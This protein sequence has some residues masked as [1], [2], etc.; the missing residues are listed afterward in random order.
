MNN[1]KENNIE[2]SDEDEED[3]ELEENEDDKA[4]DSL[5]NKNNLDK[6]NQNIVDEKNTQESLIQKEENKNENKNIK[7]D[8]N[9]EEDSNENIKQKDMKKDI[10]LSINKEN[11]E[12]INKKNFLNESN[13]NN[14]NSNEIKEKNDIIIPKKTNNNKYIYTTYQNNIFYVDETDDSSPDNY[15]KS[16]SKK[17]LSNSINNKSIYKRTLSI[18]ENEEIESSEN[19]TESYEEESEEKDDISNNINSLNNSSIEK[20]CYLLEL[21]DNGLPNIQ[22]DEIIS[23]KINSLIN[24]SLNNGISISKDI[25]MITNAEN[26]FPSPFFLNSLINEIKIKNEK[27]PNDDYTYNLSLKHQKYLN[28]LNE[29][30]NILKQI[31]KYQIFPNRINTK[32]YF[33]INC[34]VSGNVTFIFL[35]KSSKNNLIQ[36]TKPFHILVNPLININN[37]LIEINQIQMQRVIPKNIGNLEKDFDKFYSK[38]SLLGYNFIHFHSFQKLSK[39]ENIFLIK[40]QNDL[41]DRLFLNESNSNNNDI[42]NINTKQKYQLLLNSIKNLKN[43]YSIGSITDIILNQT[44]SESSWIFENKDCTYNLKNTPWLNVAYELDQIL[45]EYSSLFK[46]KKVLCKSAPYIYNIND[47]E[48]IISEI[49][50]L[51]EKNELEQYF[52]INEE[53]YLNEFKE[54]Y[55]KLKNEEFKK[56]FYNKKNMILND[57]VKNCENKEKKLAEIFTDINYLY[58]LMLQCCI[59]YG[60]ERFGVKICTEFIAIIILQ[61]FKEVNKIN[62]LPTENIFLSDVKNIINIINQKWKKQIKELLK[63]SLSNIKENLKYKYLQLKH[64]KKIDQLIDSYFIIKNKNDPS[65]IF[66]SNGWLMESNDNNNNSL[67]INTVKYGAWHH[68]KRNIIINKN[69]IKINYGENIENTSLFLINHITEYISNLAFI[70]DGLYIDSIRYIPINILKY[71]IYVARKVNPSI[72]LMSNIT[73]N[74][75]NISVQIKKKYTEELGINLFINELIWNNTINETIN[76][77]IKDGSSKNSNIYSENITHFNSELYSSS[78]VGENKILLGKYKSLKPKKPLNILYDSFDNKTYYEKFKK[79]SLS[80]SISSLLSLLDTSIGSTFGIDQMHLQ[81]PRIENE[82]RQYELNKDIK[83]LITKIDEMKIKGEEKLEVFLEYHPNETQPFNNYNSINS[84]HIAI[85]I[86]DYEPKIELTK[87]TNNLYMTKISIPPG[88][89]YFQYLINNEIWTYDNTQPMVED[90]NGIIYNTIDLRNQNKIIIPDFEIYKRELNKVRNYFTDKK[91][92]IYFQKNQDMCGIIRMIMDDRTLINNNI[93]KNKI[94]SFKNIL[95]ED[96]QNEE[97]NDEANQNDNDNENSKETNINQ[98]SN[99]LKLSKNELLSKSFEYLNNL[100][101]NIILNEN[102]SFV[103]SIEKNT[104]QNESN[105]S[106]TLNSTNDKSSLNSTKNDVD[107]T[108]TNNFEIYDGYAI[109][110]FPYFDN[111]RSKKGKG[112]ITI[113]GKISM[114][115]GCYLPEKN[116]MPN[117]SEII[118]D[119]KLKGS[120]NEVIFTKDINYLKSI[121][122]IKYIENQTIIEFF[123][124]PQNISFIFKFK[125]DCAHICD[126]LNNYLEILLNN[127]NDLINYFDETDI[128]KLLYG[129][130][131]EGY[132]MKINLFKIINDSNRINN[133]NKLKYKFMYSGINQLIELIK[134]IKKTENQDLFLNNKTNKISDQFENEYDFIN[135]I[136][137]RKIIA[138]SLYKDIYTNDNCIKYLIDVLSKAKSFNL[139]YNFIKKIIYPKYKLLPNFIKPRYFEKIITSIYQNIIK[140]SLGKIPKYLLNFGELSIGLSLTRYQFIKSSTH[141]PFDDKLI[142]LYLSEK[143]QKKNIYQTLLGLTIINGLPLRNNNMNKISTRDLLFSFNSLFLIPKLFFEAKL[144]L[145]LIGSTMKYGL[146][147][148]YIENNENNFIYN[149]LDISW[150][151]IRAI[152]EYISQSQDYNLLKENI[153]LINVPEN[154]D[155][156]YLKIKDKNKAT[157][158]SVE[159]IIQLIF[160]YHAQGI[161]YNDKNDENKAKLKKNDKAKRPKSNQNNDLINIILDY[162][163][164]F[165][166]KKSVNVFDKNIKIRA[167]SKYKADIE[168]IS[169]LYDCI[170]FVIGINNNNYYPYKDVILPSKNK[171]SFYEWSLLIKKSFEKEF[172]T[173]D[174]FIRSNFII[175]NFDNN[176][177][178]KVV[179]IIKEKKE[180]TINKKMENEFKLNQNILLAIYYSPYLFSKEVIIQS[181]DY[182]EKY[183]LMDEI[184]STKTEDSMYKLKGIKVFDKSNNYQEYTYLYGIYLT[185][186]IN[187]FYNLD[188]IYENSAE[189]IRYISKKLYPYIQYMK[190]SNYMGLPEIIEEDGNV[191]EDGNK[192][193]LKSFAII[194]ELIEKISHI[195]G[196]SYKINESDEDLLYK[197]S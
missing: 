85:N 106:K 136:N 6:I 20:D 150:L 132:E 190:E 186:K 118:M 81:L 16:F 182:I 126:D 2:E 196:K 52:M 50:T 181:I 55:S 170:N 169:L 137:D 41:N 31:K 63:L 191:S 163:T 156:T 152:K 53:K 22:N 133:S 124:A 3:E 44:S 95:S 180:S 48:E 161:K 8:K 54:F 164:G 187:Y 14:S 57:L 176:N 184:I 39:D 7:N 9:L 77:L 17:K 69:S 90:E 194:Y 75:N 195:C 145:K 110:C 92:E 179:E 121:S 157:N 129:N 109:I 38:V 99:K 122:K 159:N 141:S 47:I 197:N 127:G 13:D 173:N 86:Y 79:L 46:N 42:T 144:I 68:L 185:L 111:E 114:I 146:F 98:N 87:I 120:K 82:N 73:T 102:K 138:Q 171:L 11:K 155:I 15:K 193:D 139:I 178:E 89:Y 74:A 100:D 112:K 115:C 19:E 117:I 140:I 18:S 168:I 116:I 72:I 97:E 172:I 67:Y 119:K 76:S 154:I 101:K 125:N 5:L 166:F 30:N 26:E 56:N 153:Y 66:L 59:N 94:E 105:K 113:P 148:D 174:K 96:T 189:I 135:S 103:N 134:I 43:K 128:N 23:C 177:N 28:N 123:N 62:K 37:K 24:I 147:P 142:E 49:N 25:F 51:I 29:D 10:D 104:V 60:Y 151:Y 34:K 160:Q 64:N 12:E 165:I 36:L 71:F 35:Y 162:Q 130:E 91:S 58:K 1:K 21:N 158:L 65:E 131:N 149:S 33:K 93:E 84:I 78:F 188:S 40:D 83:D 61:S 45:M 70:F 143:K 4:S 192:S 175:K 27:I 107:L 88:K 183:F 167:N 32:I 80:I 108:N